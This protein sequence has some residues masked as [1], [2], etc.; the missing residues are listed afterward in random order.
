MR[1]KFGGYTINC[2]KARLTPTTKSWSGKQNYEVRV[3][4]W[5]T[6]EIGIDVDEWTWRADWLLEHALKEK[7]S[8][9]HITKLEQNMFYVDYVEHNQITALV[10][11]R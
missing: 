1:K 7:A 6:I 3:E 4:L 10:E 5:G 11:A 9:Y 8:E 2:D